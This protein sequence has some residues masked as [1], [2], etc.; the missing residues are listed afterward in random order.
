VRN[1][2]GRSTQQAPKQRLPGHRESYN[3]PDEYL[4]SEKVVKKW[5]KKPADQRPP[6]VS[7]KKFDALRKVPQSDRCVCVCVCVCV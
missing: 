2:G 4:L 5:M 6:L 7:H 1:L 3:P